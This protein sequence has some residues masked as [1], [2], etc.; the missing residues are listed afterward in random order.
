MRV[1]LIKLCLQRVVLY[2]HH[3]LVG[4]RHHLDHGVYHFAIMS[5]RF[6]NDPRP[7]SLPILGQSPSLL[8][9]APY[10]WMSL[11]KFDPD[12]LL[13]LHLGYWI[14]FPEISFEHFSFSDLDL[15]SFNVPLSTS[16]NIC[17]QFYSLKTSSAF[18]MP[19]HPTLHVWSCE[20]AQNPKCSNILLFPPPTAHHPSWGGLSFLIVVNGVRLVPFGVPLSKFHLFKGYLLH[21]RYMHIVYQISLGG[22]LYA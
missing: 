22:K 16:I 17:S 3:L 2:T 1:D 4:S 19:Y 5:L 6:P 14:W 15:W 7:F 10:Q 9:C 12:M 18:L 13:P 21:C 20:M 11:F 8:H